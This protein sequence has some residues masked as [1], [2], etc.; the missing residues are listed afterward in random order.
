MSIHDNRAG[1]EDLPRRSYMPGLMF[2][3]GA[4]V[5]LVGMFLHSCSNSRQEEEAERAQRQ[6]AADAFAVCMKIYPPNDLRPIICGQV[7]YLARE[8]AIGSDEATVRALLGR[9]TEE[10]QP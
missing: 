10:K 7:H 3:S 8:G 9:G 5:L 4:V 2:I 1:A 6:G